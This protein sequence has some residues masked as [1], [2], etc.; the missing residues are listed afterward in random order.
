MACQNDSLLNPLPPSLLQEATARA[1]TTQ[2]VREYTLALE[3]RDALL[4]AWA[5][6]EAAWEEER[7]GWG[8]ER[9]RGEA[10]LLEAMK[11]VERLEREVEVKGHENAAWARKTQEVWREGGREG[12]GD[13]PPSPPISWSHLALIVLPEIIRPSYPS[14]LHLFRP[15]FLFSPLRR[16]SNASKSSS[17]PWPLLR[18]PSKKPLPRPTVYFPLRKRST[19]TPPPAGKP[20]W[21]LRG[22]R[23]E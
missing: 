15:P 3:A 5:E 18:A 11:V 19:S 2:L 22:S 4:A 10:A 13:S 17:P 20:R 14:N 9:A 8:E 6:K 12:G 7:E 1:E 23:H 16:N 21:L